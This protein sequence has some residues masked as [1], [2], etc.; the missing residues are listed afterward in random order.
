MKK[1]INLLFK[2]R[3]IWV[4]GEDIFLQST[5]YKLGKEKICF[6]LRKNTINKVEVGDKIKV[7]DRNNIYCY[8]VISKTNE[9]KNRY[10]KCK[11]YKQD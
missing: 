7:T 9:T 6:S 10:I 1:F 4:I 8:E 5:N 2:N 3:K 11:L